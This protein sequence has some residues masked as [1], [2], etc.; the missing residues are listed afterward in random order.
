MAKP[1][2]FR[3]IDEIEN[4]FGKHISSENYLPLLQILGR[5]VVESE[6]D[7]ELLKMAYISVRLESPTKEGKDNAQR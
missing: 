4:L 6:R 3:A 1:R 7:M 5:L 2:I